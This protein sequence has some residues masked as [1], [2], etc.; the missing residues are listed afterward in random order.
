MRRL[1]CLPLLAV[2]TAVFAEDN[3]AARVFDPPK[4]PADARL[5]TLYHVDNPFPFKPAFKDKAAWET[6]AKTLREQTLVA[7]GL[8]PMPEK[9]PLKPVIHGKIDRDD[10]TIEKVYF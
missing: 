9:T 6:R 3:K 4:L 5:T 1:I 7:L 2:A 10:Y 8:W